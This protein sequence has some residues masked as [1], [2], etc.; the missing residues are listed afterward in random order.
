MKFSY[1]GNGITDCFYMA[2]RDHKNYATKQYI[3]GT[4]RHEL[5]D[6]TI[7]LNDSAQNLL[8]IPYRYS[9]L[10]AIIAETLWVCVGRGDMFFLK[11]YLSNAMKYS[12][13]GA[14][15]RGNYGRRIINY[16]TLDDNGRHIRINQVDRLINYLRKDRNTSR[17]VIVI[18]D[19]SDYHM[20]EYGEERKDEPCTIFIQYVV[21]GGEL[22][23]LVRMRSNDLILGCF[24]VNIFEWTFLQQLIA[25][26][27]NIAPGPYSVNAVSMHIYDDWM[28][29]INLL[30]YAQQRPDIYSILKP[31]KLTLNWSTFK[32]QINK[33][34]AI[35][36]TMRTFGPTQDIFNALDDNLIHN[37]L[38][39][40]FYTMAVASALKRKDVTMISYSILRMK[41][42]VYALSCIEYVARR[43]GY[44]FDS[45]I[46]TLFNKYFIERHNESLKDLHTYVFHSR[47]EQKTIDTMNGVKR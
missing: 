3:R 24:N 29:R 30:L 22:L 31:I 19:G 41:N 11:Y 15:W 18:P 34:M 26:E 5:L 35:E 21:R 16:N 10:P 6:Y 8:F 38:K 39:E 9:N 2:L 20:D 45:Y 25:N 36:L 12:D 32:S 17:A 7:T 47:H 42:E 27:I 4:T 28:K 1:E 44:T 43:L 40:M 23:C 37:D 13:D 33:L 14:T 46:E